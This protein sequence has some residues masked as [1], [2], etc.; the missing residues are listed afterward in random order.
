M[1]GA[2]GSIFQVLPGSEALP[3]PGRA[4]L[5]YDVAHLERFIMLQVLFA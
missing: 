1:V 5:Y 4:Y 2:S 3:N